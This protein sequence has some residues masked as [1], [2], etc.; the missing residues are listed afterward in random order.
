MIIAIVMKVMMTD[1]HSDRDVCDNDLRFNRFC[2]FP[3]R[4]I[5]LLTALASLSAFDEFSH[6]ISVIKTTKNM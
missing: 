5:D 6:K 2:N 3:T 4:A 1:D